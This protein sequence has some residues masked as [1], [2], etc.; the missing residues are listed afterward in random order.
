MNNEGI[1]SSFLLHCAPATSKRSYKRIDKEITAQ[2]NSVTVVVQSHLI[3]QTY[4]FCLYFKRP[5]QD[6]PVVME[7][8]QAIY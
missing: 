4:F 6:L 5:T 1:T 8:T 3:T 2:K 7:R